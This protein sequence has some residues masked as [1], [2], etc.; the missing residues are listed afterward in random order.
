MAFYS[1]IGESMIE[2]VG[3]TRSLQ[4]CVVN[5]FTTLPICFIQT[6]PRGCRA[7]SVCSAFPER[8]DRNGDSPEGLRL[9]FRLQ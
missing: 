2:I 3:Y 8:K 9:G 6:Q 5:L 4:A 7:A 1:P